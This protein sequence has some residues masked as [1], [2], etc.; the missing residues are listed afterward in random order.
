MELAEKRYE[1]WLAQQGLEPELRTELDAMQSDTEKITDAFYR[2]L[3]F[4]TAGLRGVLGAGTNRMNVYVIRRATQAVA[5]YLNETDLPK[6]V[7]IGHDSRIKSDVFAREAAAVFAANGITAYLYPR[8]EPVPALSFAVRHLHCGLGVCVTASHNPAEYNGYKVYGADGCQ[9]TPEAAKR[10]VAL[11]EHMDY[12]ASAKTMDFD[13]ALAAGSIRYIPDGVLDAFV[14]AV[15]AQRVGSGEGIANLKLVYTPLNGAGLEC[16]KK[17]TQKLGIRNMTIVKEQEQPDGHFPTCPY[18]NP[19]I[20]QAMELGLQYCD[21]VR[22]DILIGT[23]PDCDRCGTAVPDGKGGYRLISG[24]EMGVILLDFICRSRIANGTM[25]ENPVAVTTIV[26][27]DM[28]TAVAKKYGVELRRVLTGFKYIGEQI[29]LLE[30]GGHPERYIFGFEESYGYLSGTHARDKDGVNA[31]LLICQMA[32]MYQKAGVTLPEVLNTLYRTY[33]WYENGQLVRGVPGANGMERMQAQLTALR[34]APP[35][36]L[37][38]MPI[39]DV[40]DYA[41]GRDGLPPA[42]MLEFR[43]V[44]GRVLLRPSGTEPKLKLYMEVHEN[45]PLQAKI[46]YTALR[47]ACEALL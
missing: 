15:Y 37:A 40:W 10:V 18:P 20:R 32:T 26:S 13:A 1:Q 4:G 38:G 29:A 28:V 19:E 21:R 36:T 44:N 17:L 47:S 6:T 7:A 25:P 8:L 34:K 12:F 9:M 30:Q 2:D 45:D 24:N 27:T 35:K 3:E 22:P 46:S 31:V 14:D 5:Q 43:L 39:E 16:V 33:G 42:D 41:D 11:L 23:D